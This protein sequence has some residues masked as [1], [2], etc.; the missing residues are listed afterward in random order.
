M[1]KDR[2]VRRLRSSEGHDGPRSIQDTMSALLKEA[3]FQQKHGQA[4]RIAEGRDVVRNPGRAH[5]PMLPESLQ[6][7]LFETI[8]SRRFADLILTAATRV[9]MKEFVS[10]FAQAA[11][12]R[13]H[14]VE[15]RHTILLVGPPGTGKTS[16]ASAVAAELAVPF[17]TVRYDGLVGSFLGETASRLQQIVDYAS[18]IPCV[19]FFDEFDTV[20]KERADAHETGEI[21]RVVSSLLLHMDALP[22]NCVIVCAT[23]HPELLDRA[24]WRRF[25]I[26]IELPTPGAAELKDWYARTQRSFG[27]LGMSAKEF[28]DIFR[29]ETL[30]E[31]EAVTLDA[32]RKHILSCGE[33]T[34]VGAFK[35]A[36]ERWHARRNLLGG[37]SGARSNRTNKSR[38]RGTETD[39]RKEA[40][41]SEGDLLS[42]AE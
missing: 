25:E 36:L 41:L 16:L 13:S 5:S 23:N 22:S 6:G 7:L 12:L 4:S 9:E 15:P 14:S 37:V 24:V 34:T 2:A 17:L 11:L 8:P 28:V 19:L 40:P 3:Y 29:G 38:G 27:D 39:P 21:K 35:L 42:R 1:S 30:S 32:R 10:E 20:G 18:H 33:L 31:V 26:R